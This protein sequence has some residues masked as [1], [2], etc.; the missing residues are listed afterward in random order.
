MIQTCRAILLLLILIAS[1]TAF[2]QLQ[3]PAEFLGYNLGEQWTPHYKVY[4]YFHHVAENSDMV[5]IE[6]YGVTYEGRELTHVVVT[7]K[8]N[9]SNLEEIRFNNLRIAGFESGEISENTK[10]IVWLSYNV[11]GN[12]ASSSE[13]AM[14]T[15]YELIANNN[16]AWLDN[17]VIIIDPMLNPD[18]RDKY[19]NWNKSITGSIADPDPTAREHNEP[20]PGARINHYYFD[21]NR[22]WA[23]QTQIES[24]QRTKAY[25]KWMPHVH[26]DYHSREHLF[27]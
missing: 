11:H 2:A 27:E 24:Q 26:V 3:S 5:A 25:L 19:V 6:D 10:A 23:W 12:E 16:A 21:L 13:A 7:S 18:G 17:V 22:D 15:I 20:W 4:N 8:E 1:S 14:N 9:H